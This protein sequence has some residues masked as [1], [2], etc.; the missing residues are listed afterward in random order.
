[1]PSWTALERHYRTL[2]ESHLR[3]QFE[4]DPERFS[5]FSVEA[6]GLF[7]DYSKN[8]LTEETL[9]LLT[10]LANECALK[11]RIEDMFNGEELN[12]SEQRAVLHTALRQLSENPVL[13]KGKNIIPAIKVEQK[14]VRKLVESIHTGDWRGCSGKRITDIVNIGI[15]GSDLG[16]RMVVSALSKRA[17]KGL[18]VHFVSNVDG[19]ELSQQLSKLSPETTLFVIV[20]KT[21]TT[22]ETMTNAHSAKKWFLDSISD[23]AAVAKHFVAVSSN[24]EAVKAF[25]IKSDN[26]FEIWDWVGGRF[27]LWSSVGLSIALS[28]GMDSFEALLKGAFRMDCHFREAPLR[29]NMPV[30]L[31]LVGIWNRN[32]RKASSYGVFPYDE[33]LTHFPSYLQQVDMESNGKSVDKAGD[34]LGIDT[35]PVVWGEVGVNGQHAFYQ[36]I[37]QGT[38]S[39]PAD[40]IAVLTP[41]NELKEHHKLLV[42]NCFAQ[43]EAL[44]WGKTEEEAREELKAEGFGEK[45]VSRLIGHKTFRGNNPTNTILMKQ[46]MPETLGA[47]IALYEHKIAVQGLVWGINSFDQWGVELGKQLATKIAK[48]IDEGACGQHDSS[49]AGLLSRYKE[50][51]E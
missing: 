45:E 7:L 14:R 31:A 17:V 25:G 32:F 11:E 2:K 42:A 9:S 19:E 1:M 12:N 29:E 49:T 13:V 27:S 5:K 3:T 18:E 36:A 37:H 47:L 15:G 33:R 6:A 46:L 43:T 21:F 30:L 39:I 34:P 51:A 8:N 10:M 26:S 35:A 44:M 40:F 28:I 48:E 41:D 38:Q 24:L 16:P 23:E 22:L 4:T 50:A 20:S